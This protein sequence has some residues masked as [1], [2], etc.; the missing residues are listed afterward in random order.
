MRSRTRNLGTIITTLPLF[1]ALLLVSKTCF[2]AKSNTDSN[3][4]T[5]PPV[6]YPY[7]HDPADYP[8]YSRRPSP[9]PR[10]PDFEG[11]MQ[12]K[13]PMVLKP[14][15]LDIGLRTINPRATNRVEHRT[16]DRELT[17]KALRVEETV[18]AKPGSV[19]KFAPHLKKV[20]ED[21]GTLRI[22]GFKQF[23]IKG[24]DRQNYNELVELKGSYTKACKEL[25]DIMGTAFLGMQF[26]EADAEYMNIGNWFAFPMTRNRINQYLEFQKL[27]HSY[28]EQNNNR[29]L[30]H[31]NQAAW[32]Y[33]LKEGTTTIAEAQNFY[34]GRTNPRIHNAFFRGA[35]KQYGNLWAAGFASGTEWGV[36]SYYSEKCLQELRDIVMQAYGHLGKPRKGEPNN[37]KTYGARQR[38][39]LNDFGPLKGASLSLLRRVAYNTYLQNG[40]A[41]HWEMGEISFV[42][43]DEEVSKVTPMGVMM[44]DIERFVKDNPNPGV[45]QVPTAMLVD[46]ASGWRPPIKFPSQLPRRIEYRA[47]PSLLYDQGDHLTNAALSFLYPHHESVGAYR[48]QRYGMSDTPHGE[49]DVLLTDVIPEI[50]NRYGVIFSAGEFKTD[51]LELRDKLESFT[52]Q[53]GLLILTAANAQKLWPKWQIGQ[54]TLNFKSGSN[55]TWNASSTK[56]TESDDFSLLSFDNMPS[57]ASII[58]HCNNTPAIVDIPLGKGAVTVLLS[59]FGMNNTKRNIALPAIDRQKGMLGSIEH[60]F[61]LLNHVQ[62][63]LAKKIESQQIFTLGNPELAYNINRRGEGDYW[64][65]IF[66]DSMQ[67]QPFNISANIG[68]I[69]SIKEVP[70]YDTAIKSQPE[71]YPDILAGKFNGG[72]SD[73]NNIGGGDIR[74]FH[75]KLKETNTRTLP[76]TKPAK[77]IY[78]KLL[79]VPHLAGLK[80]KLVTW[81]SFLYHFEGVKLTGQSVLDID[82]DA[83]AWDATW[84]NR[85]QIRFIVDAR[86]IAPDK[87]SQVIDKLMLLT[88]AKDVFATTT[89]PTIIKRAKTAGITIHTKNID[90]LAQQYDK[91]ITDNPGTT[92]Y[93]ILNRYHDSWDDVYHDMEAIWSG[94]TTAKLCGRLTNTPQKR[95]T[96]TAKSENKNKY[97]SYWNIIDLPQ[98]IAQTLNF[99]DHFGGVK[100]D[101][102]YLY[103]SDLNKCIADADWLIDRKLSAVVDLSN[104]I[105]GCRDL[106]LV[107]EQG[108]QYQTSLKKIEN[109]FNKMQHMNITD[110]LLI[111]HGNWNHHKYMGAGIIDYCNIA[112]KFGITLHLRNSNRLPIEKYASYTEPIRDKASNLRFAP[113]LSFDWRLDKLLDTPVQS[114]LVCIAGGDKMMYGVVPLPIHL[115]NYPRNIDPAKLNSLDK[116]LI[117]DAEYLNDAELAS[118]LKYLGW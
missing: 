30:P 62:Q 88:H 117:L 23:R 7:L 9:P 5:R 90:L 33:T 91:P 107:P 3:I 111:T 85:K 118:D 80:D 18:F 78:N 116:K 109:I 103:S 115:N 108:Y 60:P 93:Q 16:V 114:D 14:Q 35:G 66:N 58:A 4:I 67:S 19:Q 105:R 21:G 77:R 71:Y 55:I 56:Q 94:N 99:F 95:A 69:Q 76:E 61:I 64:L 87:L 110:A 74:I 29:I 20:K 112:K 41:M 97:L 102:L 53:G 28:G 37:L 17:G 113:S 86:D 26:G 36:K 79:A 38:W 65:G 54:K 84:F 45:L 52:R 2:A 89:D 47:W 42:A 96:Q 8:D 43:S 10:W 48:N 63:L 6:I 98:S 46:F 39:W 40:A 11:R 82:I 83:L 75:V 51:T 22:A 44:M 104:M 72:L 25:Y 101:A 68:D 12:F 34:R 81:P 13:N 32:H 100:I 24:I 57:D 106:T 49:A 15:G 27:F 92:G 73:Q 31:H 70:L 59:P 50:L 1:F